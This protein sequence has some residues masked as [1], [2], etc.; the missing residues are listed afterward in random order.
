[1]SAQADACPGPVFPGWRP[2]ESSSGAP[3]RILL[4]AFEEAYDD[5][6]RALRSERRWSAL[7]R[8]RTAAGFG[9]GG[10]SLQQLREAARRLLAHR[11]RE[12]R[13]GLRLSARHQA[14]LERSLETAAGVRSE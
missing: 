12:V 10:G 2:E 4:D 7:P 1:V 14:M 9:D 11:E 8:T 13:R 3:E 5:L 6:I